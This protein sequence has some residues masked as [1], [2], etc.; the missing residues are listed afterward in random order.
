MTDYVF[1]HG[2]GQGSW[3]WDETI[4]ALRQQSPT[5]IRTLA[6]DVPGCGTKRGRNT[7]GIGIDEIASELLADIESAGLRDVIL[8]GHSQAGQPMPHMLTARP[9]LF[10]RAIFLSCSIPLPGQNVMGMI[11]NSVQGTNQNE[12]GWPLDPQTHSM[13]ERYRIMFCNDM[14]PEEA[15]TFLAKLGQDAWPSASYT[16]TDW[17]HTQLGA[18]PSSYILC[19]RDAILPKSWQEIFAQR[20]RCERTITIDSGHQAMTTRPQTLAETLRFEAL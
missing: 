19:L 11:G 1:L 15:D 14:P 18:V 4:A 6:L 13:E 16:H 17:R 12:V 3:V 2:G 8:I 9:D 7:N 20:Y 10:R 5:Q